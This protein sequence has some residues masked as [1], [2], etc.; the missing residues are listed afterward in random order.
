MLPLGSAPKPGQG[1]IRSADCQ[2]DLA[3]YVHGR[4]RAVFALVVLLKTT[5]IIIIT[6]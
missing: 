2:R 6:R 5:T 1:V 4:T 3:E